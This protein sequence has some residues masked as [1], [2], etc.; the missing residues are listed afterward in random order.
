MFIIICIIIISIIMISCIII[1]NI[2]II[3]SIITI[4]ITIMYYGPQGAGEVPRVEDGQVPLDVP[5][6]RLSG[7]GME[8]NLSLSLSLYIYM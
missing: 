8:W 5:Q 1:I 4:I 6:H 3:I 2:I 7:N